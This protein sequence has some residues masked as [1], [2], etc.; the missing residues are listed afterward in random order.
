M[1]TAI[2][3]LLVTHLLLPV[4]LIF[5]VLRGN[6]PS[7]IT[8]LI[9]VLGVGAYFASILLI[10]SWDWVGYPLRFLLPVAFL[11]RRRSSRLRRLRSTGTPWWSK[12]ASLGEWANLIAS[13]FL[14]VFFGLSVVQ[15]VGGL[16]P[17][18]PAAQLSFPLEGGVSYVGHGGDSVGLNYHNVETPTA[19]CGGHFTTHGSRDA[20]LGTVSCGTRPLRSLRRRRREPMFRGGVGNQRRATRPQGQRN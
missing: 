8:W 3:I 4:L 9:S 13:A 6:F 2:I 10:G 5:W 1:T 7:R 17:E 16:S 11:S 20:G 18:D 12:P 14:I 19:L 15:S